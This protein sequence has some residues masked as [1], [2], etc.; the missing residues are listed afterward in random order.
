M[1]CWWPTRATAACV[2]SRRGAAVALT[3][4]HKPHRRC[5]ERAHPQGPPL[6]RAEVDLQ[7]AMRPDAH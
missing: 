6:L 7:V 5:R 1:S 4:D 3:T 2:C